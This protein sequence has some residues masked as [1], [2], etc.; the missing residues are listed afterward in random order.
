VFLVYIPFVAAQSPAPTQ[1]TS[2]PP[3]AVT[4]A[5]SL[6][7][8]PKSSFEQL[9]NEGTKNYQEKKFEEAVASFQSAVAL[10]PQNTSALTDLG[11]S[12]YQL[13]KKGLAI[14]YFRRA[15]FI[16]PSLPEAQ[17]ALRFAQ[18]ELDIKEIPHQIESYER[19]RSTVLNELSLTSFHLLTALLLFATGFVWLNYF[20]RKRKATEL[21]EVP[22]A[23]PMIGI[24]F[25][26]GFLVLLGLTCAKA[27]DLSMPRATV[28]ADKV[29]AQ[30]APGE[31]QNT[32]FDLYAGFEVVLENSSN[33]WAQVYY[34]G[35]LTGWVK[36]DTLMPI[37][38]QNA[39]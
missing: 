11:L 34:P 20:G 35:G 9:F 37:S 28:I 19:L 23:V 2:T 26:L 21:E 24:L 18:Q 38:G 13:H 14:A 7:P 10:N 3:L 29:S 30:M 4:P 17:S 22:P 36:K 6:T 16:D 15:L 32:L 25:G 1:S 8:A 33:D 39:F 27:Y 5:P 31:G 12:Y